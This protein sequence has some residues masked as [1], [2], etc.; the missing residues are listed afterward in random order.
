MIFRN[1]FFVCTHYTLFFFKCYIFC[2]KFFKI[3]KK[4]IPRSIKLYRN[5]W[6]KSWNN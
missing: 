4:E 2:G 5:K 3:F 6:R 1:R